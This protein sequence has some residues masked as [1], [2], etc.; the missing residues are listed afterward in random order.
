[1]QNTSKYKYFSTKPH[2]IEYI[3]KIYQNVYSLF[4]DSQ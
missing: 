4:S 3:C 1:L 2:L